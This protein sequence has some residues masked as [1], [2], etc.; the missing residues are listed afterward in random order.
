MTKKLTWKKKL[1]LDNILGIVNNVLLIVLSILM[2]YPIL[3]IFITAV[4]DP[5]AFSRAV[6]QQKLL[7]VPQGFTMEYI[8]EH[9]KNVEIWRAYGNTI[10]Y[11][12]LGTA[13]SLFL[14]I[15]CAYVLS[16]RGLKIIKIMSII[17]VLTMWLKPG[18]IA[19]YTNIKSL[20]MLGN[21]MGIMLPFAFSAYNV[22]L[23][24]TYFAAIPVDIDESAQI[25]GA[26]HF[27]MLTSIYIPASGPAIT[28]VGLFYAIDRWNG[29]FW[30]EI[31]LQKDK[32]YPLQV[33][34]K[35]MLQSTGESGDLFRGTV[36]AFALIII[37]IVPIMI[38]F[39][40]IQKYFKKGVMVGSV[41]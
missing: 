25:D 13:I 37:A 9:L 22:I 38:I 2:V 5:V 17:V 20:G 34:V 31:V 24:R 30:A 3:Y 41:K 4:S 21:I 1:N 32:L 11:T 16:R 23:L 39:P 15:T 14:S 10:L 36:S 12:L 40:F 7:I 33:L 6:N 27:R 26:S 8:M 29:Y 19:T 35:K 28:T 18:M